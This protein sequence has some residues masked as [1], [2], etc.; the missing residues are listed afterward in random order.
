MDGSPT[1]QD[2]TRSRNVDEHGRIPWSGIRRDKADMIEIHLEFPHSYEVEEAGEVPGS[3][4]F[5]IPQLFFP[6][7]K[8]RP[9]HDGLWLK[10][11]GASGKTWIGVFAFGYSSPPAFSRVVGSPDQDRVCVIARGAAYLVNADEPEAWE[12]IRLI[13][14]LNVRAIPG[15][16]LLILSDFTRLAAYGSNGLVWQSPRVCWDGLKIATVTSDTIEGSGYDPRTTNELRFLV[17]LKT[18]RSLLP[19]PVSSDGKPLW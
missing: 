19:S 14:V 11:K 7:P 4:K 8:G 13:P 12:Q 9:E 16:K 17:D 15:E 3:G 5:S 10:I 6:P 1:Y 2:L 18:G